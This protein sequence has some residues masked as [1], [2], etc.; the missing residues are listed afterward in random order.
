MG[1]CEVRALEE[2]QGA[3]ALEWKQ[4]APSS[5]EFRLAALISLEF[6]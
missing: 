5:V 4:T 3:V 6:A 2:G 1:G